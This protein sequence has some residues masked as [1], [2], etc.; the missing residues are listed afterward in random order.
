M[1]PE[2]G[3]QEQSV[4]RGGDASWLLTF[5]DLLSLLLTF[6]VLIYSMNSVQ[7]D[8]WRTVVTAFQREFNPTRAMVETEE[9]DAPESMRQSRARGVGP[10]YLLSILE[11]ATTTSEA[12]AGSKAYR[13]GDR[14]VLSVPA[15]RLFDGKT[16]DLLPDASTAA[17]D[18][19]ATFSQIA[20]RI[21]I[22][23]HTDQE[24]VKSGLFRSNWELSIAR[25]QMVAGLLA[26]R[27]YT[28]PVVAVG[29]ADTRF[30]E[31]GQTL[32]LQTR[33]ELAERIDIVFIDEAGERGPYDI[34]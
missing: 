7:Y 14:V 33:Y 1:L 22:A 26:S 31:L 3:Q 34:F 28:R 19:V 4:R 2:V 25:S 21:V 32:T 16:A 30:K 12:L 10:G 23:A 6:F 11:R 24:P 8:S 17:G 13:I 9:F 20:N 29:Y 27:G 15:D 18:L 5:A